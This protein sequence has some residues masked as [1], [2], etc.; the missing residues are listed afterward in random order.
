MKSKRSVKRKFLNNLVRNINKKSKTRFSIKE[1]PMD[2]QNIFYAPKN[3]SNHI[4]EDI[5]IVIQGPLV[6]ES[7]FT[8]KTAELYQKL[9]PT[10]KIIVSTWLDNNSEFLRNK[11]PTIEFV[12]SKKP[13]T[14]GLGNV[15]FQKKSTIAGLEVAK[16]QGKSFVLKTRSDQRI[17]KHDFLEFLSAILNQFPVI[18]DRAIDQK[19]R[20]ISTAYPIS[21]GSMFIP[22]FIGDHLYYGDVDDLI[23]YFDSFQSEID[24]TKSEHN[25]WVLS[26]TKCTTLK[27]G[28]F[29][30]TIS[31]EINMTI[32]YLEKRLGKEPEYTI[33]ES[34]KFIKNYF[35]FVGF[36]EL[37]IFWP[38]YDPFLMSENELTQIF[39]IDDTPKKLMTY[40]WNFMSWF[41]LYSG[42]TNYL[43]EYEQVQENYIYNLH[44]DV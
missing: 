24:M 4:F 30:R 28:E 3:L 13:V 44:R 31:P 22:F 33:K 1:T 10:T 39:H 8:L 15:N 17:M 27:V 35:A 36:D 7:D 37:G 34:F 12:F 29:W 32:S 43:K 20:I 26:L 18:D 5:A 38:K 6:L 2:F 41:S 11:N 9:Y 21:P 19:E 16:K 14:S 42:M 25:E 40:G 23:K